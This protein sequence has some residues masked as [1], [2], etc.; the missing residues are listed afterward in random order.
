M[1]NYNNKSNLR[2]HS[3]SKSSSKQNSEIALKLS[4]KNINLKY[5]QNKLTK[6][7]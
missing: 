4:N 5:D 2:Q 1:N 6:G 3:R 7:V